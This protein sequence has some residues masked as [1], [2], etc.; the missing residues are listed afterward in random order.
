MEDSKMMQENFK[1][2]QQE[3]TENFRTLEPKLEESFK[4]LKGRQNNVQKKKNTSI[5]HE[6]NI[7]HKTR[8]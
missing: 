2:I 8:S 6:K 5:L 4:F 1:I 3:I 7:E